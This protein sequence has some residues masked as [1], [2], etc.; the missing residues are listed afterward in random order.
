MGKTHFAA[1]SISL[2]GDGK[3]Q[4]LYMYIKGLARFFT[5]RCISTPAERCA[6]Q[7]VCNSIG[8]DPRALFSL[9]AMKTV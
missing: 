7:V 4:V 9:S 1:I 2:C 5:F 8:R 6:T 3:Q